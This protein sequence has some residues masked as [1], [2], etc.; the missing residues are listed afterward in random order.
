MIAG[1][2]VNLKWLDKNINGQ[3][4]RELELPMLGWTLCYAVRGTELIF[5]NS[6][7]LLREALTGHRNQGDEKLSL[8]APVD[9]VT[10]IRL[11]HRQEVFD[12][13][14]NRLDSQRPKA[15]S[16]V[17]MN[18]QS[19]SVALP[20]EFFSGNV[21]SLLNVASSV[22]KIVIK[23]SSQQSRLHE[24]VEIAFASKL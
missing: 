12:E 5:A 20:E 23:R 6:F 17:Q 7:D 22:S 3:L 10:T 4:V 2:T 1:S 11:N 24:E 14:V 15:I 9:D 13:V 16:D 18:A 19:G 8:S 21:A